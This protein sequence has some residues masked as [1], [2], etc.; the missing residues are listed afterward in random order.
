MKKLLLSIMLLASAQCY[1]DNTWHCISRIVTCH[2]WRMEVPH[3]WLVSG[4]NGN[5]A[6]YALT[7]FPDEKHEWKI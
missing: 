3:G 6:H 2:T 4:D 7:F 5:D 1:A